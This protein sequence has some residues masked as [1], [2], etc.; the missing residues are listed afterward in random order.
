MPVAGTPASTVFSTVS[1][2]GNTREETTDQVDCLSCGVMGILV[3]V[4]LVPLEGASVKV[5]LGK[6]TLF[7]F[8]KR[9]SQFVDQVC[10][11]SK[12]RITV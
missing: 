4:K 2:G 1:S 12:Q 3:Q 9:E 5:V 7:L 10:R 8:V 6:G 11:V